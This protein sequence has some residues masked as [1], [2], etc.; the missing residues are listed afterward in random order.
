MGL[1]EN[2]VSLS[3]WQL[4]ELLN[5]VEDDSQEIRVWVEC[6]NKDGNTYLEGRRLCGLTDDPNDKFVC[7]VAGLY[8]EES[9]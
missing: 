1:T 2:Y 9:E 4:K 3:V 6:E 8:Y 5:G 7:L